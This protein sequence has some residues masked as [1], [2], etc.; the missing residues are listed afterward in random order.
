MPPT[1]SAVADELSDITRTISAELRAPTGERTRL[2]G[3][4]GTRLLSMPDDCI[5]PARIGNLLEVGQLAY[6]DGRSEQGLAAVKRAATLARRADDLP[7][8]R[9]A[10]TYEAALH[11]D[12]GDLPTVLE[13][14]A[15]A[16]ELARRAGDRAN[17]ATQWA[18]LSA[19][20][21]GIGNWRE[22]L[23]TAERALTLQPNAAVAMNNAAEACLE[24][25]LLR[26]GLAYTKRAVEVSEGQPELQHTVTTA[27]A[28]ANWA[29][30]LMEAGA[31]QLAREHIEAAMR[32]ADAARSM[33][34]R[35]PAMVADALHCALAGD[36][37]RGLALLEAAARFLEHQSG[38]GDGRRFAMRAQ[39]KI[40]LVTGDAMAFQACLQADTQQRLRALEQALQT[41]RRL[42]PS[43]AVDPASTNDSPAR[44]LVRFGTL[45]T[46]VEETSGE[47]SIRTSRL[48]ELIASDFGCTEATQSDVALAGLL[49]DIGKFAV[50]AYLLSKEER[51]LP[52]ELAS[53]EQ[54]PELGARLLENQVLAAR[55]PV[56]AAVRYHHERYDGQGFPFRLRKK[57]IPI[58]ARIVG[59]AEAFDEMIHTNPRHRDPWSVRRALEEMLR[60][61]GKRFD[62]QLTDVLV[63]RVRWLQRE[64]GDLDDCLAREAEEWTLVKARRRLRDFLDEPENSATN[65]R[66]QTTAAAAPRAPR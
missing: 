59:I 44:A 47:H 28:E 4:L 15:G 55:P 38:A 30:L 3:D 51:H 2:V 62:P 26:N 18:N 52:M 57:A 58:E 33:R 12:L 25:G 49:H 65:A 35:Q 34:A 53:F 46:L 24:L 50:P 6:F 19:F 56:I 29:L 43:S 63:E 64:Q 17:E 22:A 48:A 13:S 9:K 23:R 66:S 31:I 7:L 42:G 5:D 11:A 10:L 16:I 40:H 60:Q 39:R 20:F 37:D 32:A 21:V 14:S 61:R 1:P 45:A 36:F 41:A 27:Q 8:L 54:H